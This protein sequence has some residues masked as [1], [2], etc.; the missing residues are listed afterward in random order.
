MQKQNEAALLHVRVDRVVSPFTLSFRGFIEP[1]YPGKVS[2][3]GVFPGLLKQGGNLPAM[4]RL[5]IKQ[6]G[7]R[8]PS[9]DYPVLPVG[10]AVEGEG[11]IR[12]A[13][14]QTFSPHGDLPI[15]RASGRAQHVEVRVNLLRRGDHGDRLATKALK[16]GLVGK[17]NVIQCAVNRLKECAQILFS[18]GVRKFRCTGEDFLVHP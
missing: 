5:V 12:E 10:D 14:R 4:V 1:W 6:V 7:D 11:L 13:V 3:A 2:H 16:P 17:E 9:G 18:C 8:D 15:H